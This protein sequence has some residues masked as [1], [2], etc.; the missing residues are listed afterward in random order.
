MTFTER[1]SHI[2]HLGEQMLAAHA[3]Y[4]ASGCFSDIGEAHACRLQMQR[5]ISLRN[6]AQVAAMEAERGLS[7]A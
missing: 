4:E 6:P 3:R 1:E 7:H 2:K 5:A